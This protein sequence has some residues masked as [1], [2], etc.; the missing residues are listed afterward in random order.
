MTCCGYDDPGRISPDPPIEFEGH[1]SRPVAVEPRVGRCQL[2]PPDVLSRAVDDERMAVWAALPPPPSCSRR[3][4]IFAEVDVV[5]SVHP[6][7]MV[8]F[9][10]LV[11]DLFE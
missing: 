10:E 9:D 7:R 11:V 5:A 6:V 1:T 4:E 2:G 8:A 3:L